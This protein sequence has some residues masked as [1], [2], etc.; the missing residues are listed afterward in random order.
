MEAA[1]CLR[2]DDTC[3]VE[4]SLDASTD[5]PKFEASGRVGRVEPG[6]GLVIRFTEMTLDSFDHLDRLVFLGAS[7]RDEVHL[8]L[9]DE[10]GLKPK[11]SS[12]AQSSRLRCR[13]RPAT[14]R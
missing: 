8:E 2:S 13:R 7:N 10:L 12:Q 14:P 4:I 6:R 11:R 9:D 1:D 3:K 5:G